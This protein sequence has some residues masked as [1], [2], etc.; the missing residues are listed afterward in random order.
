MMIEACLGMTVDGI[1][2]RVVFDHPCL[3]REFHNSGFVVSPW[4]APALIFC[5]NAA[6]TPWEYRY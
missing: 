3:P 1:H 6:A 5:S 2:R 4:A